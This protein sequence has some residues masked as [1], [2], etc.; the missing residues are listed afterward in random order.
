MRRFGPRPLALLYLLSLQ[1][2]FLGLVPTAKA[3]CVPS[4]EICDGVDNDCDGSVDEE[5]GPRFVAS[6]GSD[7]DNNCLD[8]GHPCLTVGRALL[9]A[10]P[11][12]TI[13]LAPGTYPESLNVNKPVRFVGT[14]GAAST[15]VS[16]TA[17][18]PTVA[19]GISGVSLQGLTIEGPSN[20]FCV[21]VGAA[22]RI[23]IRNT[24]LSGLVLR[25]CTTGVLFQNTNSTG[26]WNRV[27]DSTLSG[28]W[29]AASPDGGI[30]IL[31]RGGNGNLEVTR[32]Q[33]VGNDGAGIRV[34]P[35][36]ADRLNRSLV[37]VGNR[38]QA[39]LAGAGT[40]SSAALDVNDARDVRVEGNQFSATSGLGTAVRLEYVRGG[41]F[42]CNRVLD[43]KEG[44]FLTRNTE[45]VA[46]HHN[47]FTNQTG[48]AVKVT[49]LRGDHLEASENI[50]LGNNPAVDNE[51][52]FLFSAIHNWWGA[53]DGP[54]G[55][56]GSGDAVTGRVQVTNF[57]ARADEPTL[58]R[59][60]TDAGW[61]QPISACFST[62]KDALDATAENG[63][64][65]VGAGS[66]PGTV[67]LTRRV[68]LEGIDGGSDC[69]PSQI[70]GTQ[71][72]GSHV[73]NLRISGVNGIT[74]TNLTIRNSGKGNPCGQATGEEIGL[75]LVNVSDSHF[76]RICAAGSGVT[77]IRVYGA[78]HRNIIENS[79]TDGML[80]DANGMDICGH[81]SREGI[82]IDGGPVCEGGPGA[83]PTGNII[84]N[85]TT[86]R[87]S[88]SVSL[89]L[90]QNT[91]IENSLL[92]GV[93]FRLWD[94]GD[95]ATALLITAS[96]GTRAI[97]N[98]I[99]N[100]GQT[101]AI[102]IQGTPAGACWTEQLETRDTLIS[103]NHVDLAKHGL[104][105]ASG[106]ALAR[107]TEI[108]CN[109]FTNSY[110]GILVDDGVDVATS[111]VFH[112]N[113]SNNTIGLRANSQLAVWAERNWWNDPSGPSG[114]GPGTGQAV[115]GDVDYQGWLAGDAKVDNDGDGLSACGG[116]CDDRDSNTYPGATELCDGKDNN[117]NGT[118][119]DGI[120]APASR[121]HLSLAT[122]GVETQLSWPQAVDATGYDVV[123]GALQSLAANGGDFRLSTGSCLGSKLPTNEVK[124]S[125]FP[126]AGD[127]FW[128]LT[129][130]VNCGGAGSYNEEGNGQ[131]ADRDPG[132]AL[133]GVAC[134]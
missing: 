16:G 90:A 7:L 77:E 39:N 34:L 120:T 121:L 98:E 41:N 63:L 86:F 20:G 25:N 21:A 45:G 110:I 96:T 104:H 17:A 18:S 123:R 130:S 94:H 93:P 5:T 92:H 95:F 100:M 23:G 3:Q 119:D 62:L 127:G 2:L 51:A 99:G 97:N 28:L 108:S 102:R 85:H 75:D 107:N 105:L 113:F 89:R 40:A 76:N 87:S 47:R 55:A 64:V 43:N 24:L 128:Y 52:N 6:V 48:S 124:D 22:D 81:R 36:E 33:F 31:L 1:V 66:L 69:S 88:R 112:N 111:K 109:T 8:A 83:L 73:P 67:T 56:G 60:A 125:Q 53:P 61:A 30:G 115:Q 4:V 37:V 122:V 131:A 11:N 103:G 129:R 27:L 91:L 72:P 134:P 80:R 132:I 71:L 68:H 32:N 12:E 49:N 42:F 9:A 79:R 57:L 58:A 59:G 15:I 13:S 74:L 114:I 126:T 14:A 70:D 84:R 44:L 35:P 106:A 29:G 38:F 10:C 117:C 78:S 82:L 118:P 133:S 19:I 26:E 50:F 65:L 116:D 46:I 54:Q 101:H